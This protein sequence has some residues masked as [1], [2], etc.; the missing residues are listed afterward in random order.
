MSHLGDLDHLPEWL[1]RYAHLRAY[2]G[3]R[4][5]SAPPEESLDRDE[6]VYQMLREDIG[7]YIWLF[8]NVTLTPAQQDDIYKA[9]LGKRRLYDRYS[10]YH[11]SRAGQKRQPAQ[12]AVRNAID[13][14]GIMEKAVLM[15]TGDFGVNRPQ[16]IN[17]VG[18]WLRAKID[19]QFPNLDVAPE[20]CLRECKKYLREKTI[21]PDWPTK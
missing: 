2:V 6:V 10:K 11:Q 8:E 7:L 16:S 13:Q 3:D 21:Q 4:H 5:Y 14:L 12:Q 20:P 19:R 1:A 9:F 17:L 15:A 18:N